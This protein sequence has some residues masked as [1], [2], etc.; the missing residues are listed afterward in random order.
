MSH[1]GGNHSQERSGEPV[2]LSRESAEAILRRHGLDAE[3]LAADELKRRWQ[4]LARRHH[5]DLG[6]DMR[7]MQEINAA[8]SFL[9]PHAAQGGAT[10]PRRASAA[11][12]SGPGPGTAALPGQF[13]TR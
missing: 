11:R 1:G 13:P 6:G 4:E 10:F 2:A 3:G 9:K 7:T 5:P 12:R 8:Y